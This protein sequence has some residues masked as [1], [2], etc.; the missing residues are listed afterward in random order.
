MIF[1]KFIYSIEIQ[2]I[3]EKYRIEIEQYQQEVK[4]T[5]QSLQDLQQTH[6]MYKY[7]YSLFLIQSFYY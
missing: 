1:I 7:F 3:M 4:Y 6:I 2:I 5:N